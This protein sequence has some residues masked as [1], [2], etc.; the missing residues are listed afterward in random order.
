MKRFRISVVESRDYLYE[1]DAADEDEARELVMEMDAN[2]SLSDQFR[3]RV[4]D[5]AEEVVANA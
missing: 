5:W 3:E 2:D 1:V 4:F